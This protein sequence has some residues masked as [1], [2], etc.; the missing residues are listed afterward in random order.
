VSAFERLH[1][2]LQHHVVNSLGWPALRP[3]QEQAIGPLLDGRDALIVGPTAGGKTEAAVL[4]LLS[5]ML[6]E[7]WRGLGLLYVCPIRALLNNLHARLAGYARLVG[8][9]ADLWHGDVGEAGRRRIRRTPP[10]VLLTTPES[11]EVM[12]VSRRSDRATLF[13]EARAVVVDELHAFAGDD[14]GWHL[15]AVLERIQHLAGRPLQRVGLSATIGSPAGLLDWLAG[16]RGTEGTVIAPETGAASTVDVG[17]DHA[18]TLDGAARVIASLH[19]GERR[20]VFVDSRSRVEQLAAA[21][22]AAGV[23]THVSHGSLGAEE[24][25]RA[26]AAFAEA[27]D[28]VIVAT[29]TLELGMD[30]GDLDRVIQVDAPLTVSSFLQRVGR[31]GRRPGTQRNCLFLTTSDDALLRAAALLQ[32]WSEGFVEPV[33]PPP[34][35]FHILAQQLL[36]LALQ[37]GGIGRTAWRDWIGGMPAFAAMADHDVAAVLDHMVG[38][39]LLHDDM[40]VLT[41]GGEGEREFGRRNFMEL[42]SVFTSPP[43]FT[44]FHGRDDLGQVHEASFHGAQDGAPVLLLGG[45][46]WRV[47]HVDWG[48]RTAH[49]EASAEPGRSRWL[50]GGGALS[51]A[52]AGAVRRVLARGHCP[53]RLYG[54]ATTALDRIGREFAWVEDGTTAVIRGPAGHPRWWTFAGL[55][56]NVVLADALPGVADARGRTDNFSVPVLGGVTP[57]VVD[58][59]IAT[60]GERFGLGPR[61][62]APEALD[63]LKFS[64]CVP[65]ALA[66]RLLRRRLEDPDTARRVLTEPVRW[67]AMGP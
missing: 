4:P 9:T 5:R 15:L 50:G 41:V 29:S 22:R 3:L 28:C 43:L 16:S 35:P 67:V 17:L 11:L 24:R 6:S 40:G 33:T 57:S 45:R 25:R 56:A 2:A 20:L 47:T 66:E 46:S 21:L 61:P 19:R 14:R 51:A 7:G 30:V 64:V 63:G 55:R 39:G 54:R 58:A 52:V 13:R 18:G 12:L 10:D 62:I 27:R 59:A 53:G 31:T 48:R 36:A 8:R 26:E 32:L 34:E 65:P 1:P 42:F 37:Q 49:V 38:R 23:A 44:V 60:A